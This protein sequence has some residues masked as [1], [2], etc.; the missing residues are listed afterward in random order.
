M[1]RRRTA[2][3]ALFALSF[4]P[5]LATAQQPV[6]RWK[7]EVELGLNGASGNSSYSILRTGAKVT[8][9]QK[10]NMEFEAAGL[11]RHG[12]NDE[13][14]IADDARA[15]LKMDLW[16]NDTWSP[17]VFADWSR[18]AIRKIDTRVSGGVG[19]K[20]LFWNAGDKDQ[21]SVSVAGLFDYQDFDLALGSTEPEIEK[22]ARWSFRTKLEKKLSDGAAFEQIAFYQPVWNRAG[23]YVLDITNSVTTK[24]LGKLSLGVEHQYLRDS[25]PQPG[26]G[27]DDQKFSVILKVAF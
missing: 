7:V 14:V 12:K 5:A 23:D 6:D 21:A 24:V 8:L 2:L 26:V 22:V 15:S 9:L 1:T 13:K 18:D 4:L 16:P 19:L 3:A 20:Y 10:E 27:S 11:V 17:F 25:T